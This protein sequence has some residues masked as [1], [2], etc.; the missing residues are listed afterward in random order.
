M[1]RIAALLLAPAA[2]VVLAAPAHAAAP[3]TVTCAIVQ[4][5]GNGELFQATGSGFVPGAILATETS[6]PKRGGKSTAQVTPQ[7]NFVAVF[8]NANGTL[9]PGTYSFTVWA[10]VR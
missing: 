1:S 9:K 8:Q 6:T 5:A 10:S 4:H 2:L 7:G 3:P